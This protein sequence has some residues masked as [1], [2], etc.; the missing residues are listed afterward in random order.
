[1]KA[2]G[3][4]LDFQA[5]CGHRCQDLTK[6]S[7]VDVDAI[8]AYARDFRRICPLQ[9]PGIEGGYSEQELQ[10]IHDLMEAQCA[11]M[12]TVKDLWNQ[13]I[14]QLSEQQK[15]S[16]L[17]HDEFN[18]KYAKCTQ[19]VAMAEGLGQKYGA[20]RRRAQERIRSEVSRDERAAGK[21]DE[22]LALIEFVCSEMAVHE[23][24]S[25]SGDVPSVS[26]ST[27]TVMTRKSPNKTTTLA[28]ASV[29]S[30][31]PP[32]N[33][34]GIDSFNRMQFMWKLMQSLRIAL[35]ARAKFLD[36]L[37]DKGFVETAST[38]L[39]W[40]DEGRLRAA[41]VTVIGS[42]P[43]ATAHAVP[44]LEDNV[45]PGQAAAMATIHAVF[46]D[47]SAIC[48]KETKQLYES[49]GLGTTIPASLEQWLAEA[50]DKLIGRHGYQER[51]WK[52]LWAQAQ[53]LDQLMSRPKTN[54]EEGDGAAL[55]SPAVPPATNTVSL[56]QPPSTT[57]PAVKLSVQGVCLL[58]LA[59]VHMALS[60]KHFKQQ[61][62][63]FAELLAVWELG[64]DKH[65]RL[66][67]PRLGSPDK[68]D[69]L[70]ALDKMESDR[71]QDMQGG[72]ASF[73]CL[74]IRAQAE[75]FR[76]F[77]EDLGQAS[78][79]LIVMLDTCLRQELLAIPPDT[80]VPK[81]HMTL[82]KL[83]K[84]QRI[85]DDVAK[86]KEDI[87][88]RRLWSG[89]E[90]TAETVGVV[91]AA[92]DMVPDLGS[93][94]SDT[95]GVSEAEA[96]A[97]AASAAPVGGKDGKDKKAAAPKKPD[98]N[99]PP[100][101]TGKPSLLPLPWIDKLKESTAVQGL[102]SSAHRSVM[103]YR[104]EGLSTYLTHLGDLLATVRADYG[105]VLHQEHSW[106]QRWK[107]QVDMLREGKL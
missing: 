14:Q 23:N 36:I 34:P 97:A 86:G 57:L 37:A 103:Q 33:N 96:A 104:D 58:S 75:R 3:T 7:T 76:Q 51:A 42:D 45:V 64:R 48:K 105:L 32:D 56:L 52:R 39:H 63:Q 107:R 85:R 81:K 98:K 66:L 43:T 54:D 28:T 12:S 25:K 41:A 1:M 87:S 20:P 62:A 93:Q 59:Q 17:C 70:A 5:D 82:K 65:E 78:K 16:M 22:F 26:E 4:A 80:A 60:T 53:R 9:K 13:D 106:T 102:V 29:A 99:A 19:E 79:G 61:V 55:E 18:A 8:V 74:L 94:P 31:A 84:A 88:Q 72:V 10:E 2:R 91:I 11:D 15:Q 89:I 83:R 50:K 46:E 35:I 101:V 73:R 30:P 47:V 92:E 44:S 90:L 6:L 38:S 24:A 100:P 71:S 21:V 68:A 69:E 40:L 95:T 67:K 77:C 27:S 49:E